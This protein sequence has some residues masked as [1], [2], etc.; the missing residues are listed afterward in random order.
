MSADYK[1]LFKTKRDYS[2]LF[3][4]TSI[5]DSQKP[6]VQVEQD[7]KMAYKNLFDKAQPEVKSITPTFPVK[8]ERKTF[9]PAKQVDPR[10]EA[11]QKIDPK[12]S[13]YAVGTWIDDFDNKFK[14][15]NSV[16]KDLSQREMDLAMEFSA[17]R[18][19]VQGLFNDLKSILSQLKA[20]EKKKGLLSLILGQQDEFKLTQEIIADVI[21]NIKILLTEFKK[22]SKYNNSMFLRSEMRKI[23]VDITELKS[24]L[25]CAL[26]ACQYMLTIDDFKAASRIER[27]KQ[28]TG[29]VDLS[30][31]QLKATYNL[32]EKDIESYENLE[33][34]TI[35]YLYIKIQTLMNSTLDPEAL[36]VINDIDKL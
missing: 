1:N 17:G 34:V 32:L 31:L 6:T 3:S 28:V 22:K 11:I 12:I 5:T 36:K 24:D 35:P 14:E 7:A 18:L 2:T 23:E 16:N 19:S 30:A 20:P 29:L 9:I 25:D 8:E 4:D 33:E 13:T 26:V 27:I 15:L 10:V 21:S